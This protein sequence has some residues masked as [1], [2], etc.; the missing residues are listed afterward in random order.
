MKI[1]NQKS[2][3][4][5]LKQS[6]LLYKK[7][8]ASYLGELGEL[9]TCQPLAHSLKSLEFTE[10]VREQ[11]RVLDAKPCSKFEVNFD[12]RCIPRFSSYV[13]TLYEKNSSQIYIWTA[14]SNYCGIFEIPSLL[15]FNFCFEFDV[16][17]EGI[18]VLVAANMTDKLVLDFS[19]DALCGYSL[20][21]ETKGDNWPLVKY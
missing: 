15:E 10:I 6:K 11:A 7:H 18:I 16:N 20:E 3:S 12:M 8:L 4:S 1:P 21:I 14:K 9:V 5:N 19:Y 2:M 17:Q 13:Q